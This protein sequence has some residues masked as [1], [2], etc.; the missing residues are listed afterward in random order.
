[1]RVRLTL[2]LLAAC[3]AKVA[4]ADEPAQDRPSDREVIR[5]G[6][7]EFIKAF[8]NGDAAAAAAHLTS[9]IELIADGGEPVSGREAIQRLYVE[10]FASGEREKIELKPE[11]L[12]FTS[13]DTAIE[14]GNMKTSIA[15]KAPMSQRYSLLHVRE[16]GKWLLAAIREWPGEKAGIEDLQWLI[17]TW[18]AKQA[19]A[20]IHTT[21]EWLG[22]RAFI[23]GNIMMRQKNLTVSAMQ[24][25][26]INPDTG[27]L[28][29]WIFEADGGVAQGT[30]T[31]DGDTWVFQTE[32]LL[33]NGGLMGAMNLLVR[34]NDQ[35]M[36]WQPVNLTIDD[37]TIG[38]L[39]P[40]KVTRVTNSK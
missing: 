34:I 18:S 13:R 25:I 22:N 31:R 17:G 28:G 24:V 2:I 9:G 39:P 23:R 26:G 29:I 27:E 20:E 40:M 32:G 21:Y 16:D 10:H 1:M 30:C 4:V 38:D 5:Q 6:I 15:G 12:R 37:K 19:D 35:T 8:E 7:A 36:T 11:S 33:A 3:F 14:E